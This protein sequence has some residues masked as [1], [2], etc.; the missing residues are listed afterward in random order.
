M[1]KTITLIVVVCLVISFYGCGNTNTN[2]Y[3]TPYETTEIQTRY[4]DIIFEALKIY[5][6]SEK[7]DEVFGTPETDERDEDGEGE[8]T[9][10]DVIIFGE[11]F[12]PS[13]RFEESL[14][15]DGSYV[16]AYG[17]EF[18]DFS[19]AKCKVLY[20]KLVDHFTSLYG[21]PYETSDFYNHWYFDNKSHGSK[22]SIYIGQPR[23]NWHTV[24]MHLDRA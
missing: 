3:V 11:K 8:A 23:A 5:D 18:A 14:V 1:K 6:S 9:Y 21:E 10:N 22:L 13:V 17:Y 4:E 24:H 16:L 15:E 7:A 20:K 19:E 12:T 2:N